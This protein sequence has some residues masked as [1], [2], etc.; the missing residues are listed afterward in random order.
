MNKL[1]HLWQSRA[2]GD[3]FIPNYALQGLRAWRQTGKFSKFWKAPNFF[4]VQA[5]GRWWW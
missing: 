3:M 1:Y 4:E 5:W 2:F